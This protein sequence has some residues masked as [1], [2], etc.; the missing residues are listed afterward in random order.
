M[1]DIGR[2]ARTTDRIVGRDST[3][4]DTLAALLF[5]TTD[6]QL[7]DFRYFTLPGVSEESAPQQ[8]FI[9]FNCSP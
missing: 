8:T 9:H 6:F 4:L 7:T 5:L 2:T 3:Y 1:L